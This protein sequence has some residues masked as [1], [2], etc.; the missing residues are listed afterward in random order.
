MN[1]Q[2]V[3][4]RGLKGGILGFKKGGND[5]NIEGKFQLGGNVTRIKAYLFSSNEYIYIYSYIKEGKRRNG[6]RVRKYFEEETRWIVTRWQDFCGKLEI[7]DRGHVSPIRFLFCSW[8][9]YWLALAA[10][11]IC[12]AYRHLSFMAHLFFYR[13]KGSTYFHCAPFC[14]FTVHP[15][16]YARQSNEPSKQVGQ[17]NQK[18][19][20]ISRLWIFSFRNV[21]APSSRVLH[22]F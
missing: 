12:T 21:A 2:Q 20:W 9:Q 22:S 7:G 5:W 8:W 1:K 13:D 14:L 10:N 16:D 4:W 17:G 11:T 6:I 3:S 15:W 18:R 19:L